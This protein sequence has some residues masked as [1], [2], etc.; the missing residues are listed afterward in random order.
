MGSHDSKKKREEI[1]VTLGYMNLHCHC[2]PMLSVI[3]AIP[4]PSLCVNERNTK[5][6]LSITQQHEIT[7]HYTTFATKK[8]VLSRFLRK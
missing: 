4:Y 7:V 2:L 8:Q 5:Y 6:K 3:E 1:T